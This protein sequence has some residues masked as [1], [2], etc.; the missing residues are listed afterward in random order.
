MKNILFVCL[1]FTGLLANAQKVNPAVAKSAA[2]YNKTMVQIKPVYKNYVAQTAK[3]F[4]NRK[5]NIDSLKQ[6]MKT[7]GNSMFSD[8]TA[9][10]ISTVI[11]LVMQAMVAENE[12]DIKSTMAKMEEINK[13]KEALRQEAERIKDAAKTAEYAGIKN[14]SADM[15]KSRQQK[16]TPRKATDSSKIKV[17]IYTA[18]QAKRLDAIQKE[19]DA[20]S[21][22]GEQDQ[23][24]LQQLMEKKNQLESMISNTMKAVEDTQNSIS[25]N[26][27]AS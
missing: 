10:D 5:L 13:K 19:K 21:E 27:K 1:S 8:L 3:A 20:I 4:S 11:Q 9:L 23:L 14:M 12:A 26:L 15:D 16:E 24:H 6:T 25:N 2:F 22:M 7:P 18:E 17:P